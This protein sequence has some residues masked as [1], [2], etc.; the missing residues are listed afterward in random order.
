MPSALPH[1]SRRRLLIGSAALAALGATSVACGS[2][3]PPPDVSVLT[4]QLERARSDSQL[5]A[6]AASSAP[7]PVAAAMTAVAAERSAH[8]EA[9]AEEI[10][11]ITGATPTSST[12]S[13]SASTSAPSQPPA[14]PTPG[15]VVDALRQSADGAAQ[16]AAE[17]SGYAAGLLG[18]VA[19]SCTAAFS[20]ALAGVA[21]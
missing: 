7:P 16:A 8:A 21:S 18:S 13:T 11:R 1:L 2:K 4:A 12:S 9:L 3:N 5:A 14:P 15:A 6:G 20:V 10:T 17:E 19:A